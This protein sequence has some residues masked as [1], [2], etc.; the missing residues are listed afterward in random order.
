MENG[1]PDINLIGKLASVIAASGENKLIRYV[2]VGWGTFVSKY[3]E[4]NTTPLYD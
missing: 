2:L 4:T 1:V 3:F